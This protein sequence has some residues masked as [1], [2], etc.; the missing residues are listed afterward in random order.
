MLTSA[1]GLNEANTNKN[2]GTTKVSKVS[3]S[4][5]GPG[6]VCNTPR[7]GEPHGPL[8]G[9]DFLSSFNSRKVI[10]RLIKYGKGVA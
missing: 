2:V 10:N 6:R 9:G 5:L 7:P 1:F 4:L 8:A 3:N